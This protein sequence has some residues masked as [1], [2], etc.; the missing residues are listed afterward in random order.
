M[1]N[2]LFLYVPFK[3]KITAYNISAVIYKKQ[4]GRTDLDPNAIILHLDTNQQVGHLG[5]GI[6][7]SLG[8]Y[9]AGQT[10]MRWMFRIY[11]IGYGEI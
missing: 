11:A 9:I 4:Y 6:G 3:K 5:K 8:G 1:Q 10:S 2:P 7:S